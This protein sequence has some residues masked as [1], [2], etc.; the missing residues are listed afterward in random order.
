MVGHPILRGK[1]GLAYSLVELVGAYLLVRCV[2]LTLYAVAAS[3]DRDLRRQ[4]AITWGPLLASAA[5]LVPGALLGGGAQTLLF[6]AALLVDWVGVYLTSRQGN[7]R[8]HSPAHWTERH[9]NFILL[10][11]GASVVAIG[12]GAAQQ[13]ID[14][15]LLA[16]DAA[17]FNTWL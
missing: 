15:P 8:L 9:G 13:P 10:A 4:L 16:A 5:L 6:A 3:G 11:I 17:I 1:G 12:A 7:W 2:H 14:G